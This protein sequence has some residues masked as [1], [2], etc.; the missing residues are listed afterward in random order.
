[1]KRS[2]LVLFVLLL[3]SCTCFSYNTLISKREAKIADP[4]RQGKGAVS[5]SGTPSSNDPNAQ[6]AFALGYSPANDPNG[7]T[8]FALGYSP[9]NDANVQTAIALGYPHPP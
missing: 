2:I 4:D 7:Q 1:M 8:A 5:A 3:L 6:T 9:L